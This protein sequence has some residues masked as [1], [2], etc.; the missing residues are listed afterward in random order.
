MVRKWVA[1]GR[2]RRFESGG[3]EAM[4]RSWQYFTGP[5]YR[6]CKLTEIVV[7]LSNTCLRPANVHQ[8]QFSRCFLHK[9]DAV[10]ASSYNTVR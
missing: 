6:L 4:V 7:G 10:M 1:E 3:I 2:I 9:Q 8:E 5:V